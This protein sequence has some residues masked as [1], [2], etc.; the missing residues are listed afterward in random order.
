MAT[1]P[2]FNWE[3]TRHKEAF[4]YVWM[5]ITIERSTE[6]KRTEGGGVNWGGQF[7]LNAPT[8]DYQYPLMIH[9]KI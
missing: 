8:N 3:L 1:V 5:N 7:E 6:R 4:V 2:I 9:L